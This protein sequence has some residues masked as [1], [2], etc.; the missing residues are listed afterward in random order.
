MK[1]FSF[2]IQNVRSIN[3]SGPIEVSRI[4]A[5]LGRNESG[6]SNLLRALQSLN[7]PEGFQALNRVKD[8]PRHRRLE[9]CTDRT[10]VFTKTWEL[11]ETDRAEFGELLP[12]ASSLTKIRIGRLY[13]GSGPWVSLDGLKPPVLDSAKVKPGGKKVAAGLRARAEK[14]EDEA[15]GTKLAATATE[16]VAGLGAKPNPK[17]WADHVSPIFQ[18]VRIPSWSAKSMQLMTTSGISRCR[19]RLLRRS[20]GSR[21]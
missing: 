12:P 8:F 17:E 4:T 6:K 11:D 9:E 14:V 16:L 19:N 20:R 18:R 10:P 13:C 15:M 2:Q 1:L 21:R 5:L 7:P 3:D